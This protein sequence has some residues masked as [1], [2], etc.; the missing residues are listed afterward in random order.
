MVLRHSGESA[1]FI[2]CSHTPREKFHTQ[3]MQFHV[4]FIDVEMLLK[5]FWFALLTIKPKPG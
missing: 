4:M 5:D 2:L 1:L 3:Q